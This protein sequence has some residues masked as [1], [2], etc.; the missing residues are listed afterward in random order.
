ME[1]QW[2]SSL[3]V[4]QV[5]HHVEVAAPI[6]PVG[7]MPAV[8]V[9]DLHR[10]ARVRRHVAQA[11]LREATGSF[12][13]GLDRVD[14]RGVADQSVEFRGGDKRLAVYALVTVEGD[15]PPEIPRLRPV[16]VIQF[17]EA[18]DLIRGKRL[19]ETYVTV[20]LEKLEIDHR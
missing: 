8:P 20:L 17:D 9:P 4:G 2:V 18:A 6:G 11:G 13:D 7:H 1:K 15:G 16:A 3:Y 12:E 19:S 5:E 14:E 10:V